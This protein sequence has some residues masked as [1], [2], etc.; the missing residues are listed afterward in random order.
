M[1]FLK[2]GAVIFCAVVITALGIDAADTL[3]GKSGSMLGQ[4]IATEDST[5]PEGMTEVF[6]GQTFSCVDTYE[7]APSTAC[8]FANIS[9]KQDTQTNINIAECAATS[10]SDVSP[11]T[12]VNREQAQVLCMRAGKR[13]PTASEWHTIALG[14]PDTQACNTDGGGVAS[15]GSH[16]D[17]RS[18]AGVYDAIGNVWEW[19]DDDVIQGNYSGRMLP[20]EGYVAQTS[21]DG[22]ATMTSGTAPEEFALDYVWTN[23]TGVYGMMRGGFYRSGDDGGVYAIQAETL[24]TAA[25]VAIGFRCVR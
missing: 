20:E 5:C 24:P 17:C 9:S 13:L 8:S 1:R 23:A 14:T 6:V 19:T 18:A 12:Y 4:L 10:I 21:S 25:T 2:V 7:A 16:E 15:S 11:W 3:S 22:V